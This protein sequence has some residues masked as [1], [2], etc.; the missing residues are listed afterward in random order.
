MD[1]LADA[2][3]AIRFAQQK[4]PA[5]DELAAILPTIEKL[6]ALPPSERWPA[7]S[8]Q[9]L[10]NHLVKVGASGETVALSAKLKLNAS[11]N[12]KLVR[13]RL[14]EWLGKG[15]G[16]VRVDRDG[17]LVVDLYG[18]AIDTLKPLQGLR[19]EALQLSRTN[20]T[21]LEPL[22]G[23]QLVQINLGY[24]RK[25]ADLSPLRGMPLRYIYL[26]ATKVNDLSP[27]R[28]TPLEEITCSG[29]DIVDFSP[30]RDAPLQVVTM[31]RNGASDLA[32]LANAP[33]RELNAHW[34]K[35]AD[36]SPLRGKLLKK[37]DISQTNVSDLTP[38]RGAPLRSW[39]FTTTTASKTSARCWI[40]RS[41]KGSAS[42]S[43]A[44]RSNRCAT[45]RP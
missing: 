5:H 41:W 44:S 24:C 38:L 43:S 31:D 17:L 3:A 7:E 42:Q 30:L 22:R 6:A 10:Y 14:E 25:V 16:A 12:E 45:I 37:L 36:L 26:Y 27:L 21:S 13:Q 1:R 19:I 40:S 15:K 34:T 9:Q 35:I 32:F 18:L 23:M 8:A 29:L 39:R 28:G 2:A 4:D 20:I 33:L 11:D